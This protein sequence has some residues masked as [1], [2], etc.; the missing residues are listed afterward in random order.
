MLNRE[1][2]CFGSLQIRVLELKIHSN[3]IVL[4]DI[5][6]VDCNDCRRITTNCKMLYK[7]TYKCQR[8]C[9]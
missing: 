8:G 7:P 1:S 5:I 9:I 6:V 3:T 2:V 4:S